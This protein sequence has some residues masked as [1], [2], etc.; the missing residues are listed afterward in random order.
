MS[1][2]NLLRLIWLS[3]SRWEWGR[4]L[5]SVLHRF[6]CRRLRRRRSVEVSVRTM[7]VGVMQI[8]IHHRP[9]VLTQ[10]GIVLGIFFTNAIGLR[11]ATPTQWRSVLFVSFA[12]SVIQFFLSS[13]MVESPAWLGGKGFVEP[14]KVVARRLWGTVPPAT[15]MSFLFRLDWE[16]SQ[17]PHSCHKFGGRPFVG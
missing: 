6:I 10:L 13:L 4:A 12:A 15:R 11:F 9:G 2:L 7:P 16:N 8:C 5:V 17:L 1:E 3:D 14:K